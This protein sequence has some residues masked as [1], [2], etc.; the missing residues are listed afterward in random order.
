VC[1]NYIEGLYWILGY[2]NGHVHENWSW[3][4]NFRAAPFCDDIFDYLRKNVHQNK[5][6]NEIN[7]SI[8][9]EK[10]EPFSN[11]KQLCLVLPKDSIVTEMKLLNGNYKFL[12][13]MINKDNMYVTSLFPSKLFVDVINKE[14]LWQSKILFEPINED[15]LDLLF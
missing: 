15:I 1:F 13:E 4:Y 12:E 11:I 6:Q 10:N 2:Y 5:I 3:Y 14:Y 8:V 7:K 9:L